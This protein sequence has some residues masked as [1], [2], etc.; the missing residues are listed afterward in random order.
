M[1]RGGTYVDF[2]NHVRSS[3]NTILYHRGKLNY[4]TNGV[5]TFNRIIGGVEDEGEDADEQAGDTTEH[6]EQF[7]EFLAFMHKMGMKV[8]AGPWPRRPRA[9]PPRAAAKTLIRGVAPGG[10]PG[11]GRRCVNCSDQAHLTRD[12]PKPELPKEKRPLI[13]KKLLNTK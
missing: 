6:S 13:F 7:D 10:P 2:R 9:P 12:C 5:K 8:P 3:L 11:G 1:Q 4:P